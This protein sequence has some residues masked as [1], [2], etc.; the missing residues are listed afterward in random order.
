MTVDQQPDAGVDPLAAPTD[1]AG[2]SAPA[3]RARARLTTVRDSIGAALGALL[4]LA[5]HVLHHVGLLAGA[6]VVTGVTGNAVFFLVGLLLSIPMLRRLYRRFGTW[7][8]PAVAIGVF[9]LA[10]SVSAFVIGPAI[11]GANATQESPAPAPI[12]PASPTV[13]PD[14]T[15]HHS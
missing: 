3:A 8:A 5:P 15:A 10:F 9:A 7:K 1:H 6:A 11:T 12:Q 14:H 13:A 2:R 4:G